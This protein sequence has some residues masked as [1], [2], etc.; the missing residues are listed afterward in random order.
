MGESVEFADMGMSAVCMQSC[1]IR[2]VKEEREWS[3]CR[4]VEST[5]I[6][7]FSGVNLSGRWSWSDGVTE[8]DGD[9]SPPVRSTGGL[10][11]TKEL[12]GSSGV[13]RVMRPLFQRRQD[14]RLLSANPLTHCTADDDSSGTASPLHPVPPP[15]ARRTTEKRAR[16]E[17]CWSH[18]RLAG[19]VRR[20]YGQLDRY[21]CVSV[22]RRLGRRMPLTH[23]ISVSASSPSI[24]VSLV[25]SGA[26]FCSRRH[27]PPFVCGAARDMDDD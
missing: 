18:S 11:P 26:I 10:D 5:S 16:Q 13:K 23:V 20:S 6:P 24:G 8:M 3:A 12:A 27:V 4:R 21:H 1:P 9:S 25:L 14:Q 17:A 7:L 2:H 19:P 22:E 15:P